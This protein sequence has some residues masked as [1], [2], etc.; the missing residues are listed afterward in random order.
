MA[1]PGT[2]RVL[3]GIEV[4]LFALVLGAVTSTSAVVLIV[5][6]IGLLL[7]LAGATDSGSRASDGSTSRGAPTV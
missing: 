1:E 6:V 5:G 4:T 3:F 2:K 7:G